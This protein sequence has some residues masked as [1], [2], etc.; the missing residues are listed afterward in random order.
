MEEELAADDRA[1]TSRAEFFTALN[2]DVKIIRKILCVIRYHLFLNL[3]ATQFVTALQKS[4]PEIIALR[5][6]F[7]E[8]LLSRDIPFQQNVDECPPNMFLGPVPGRNC[9]LASSGVFYDTKF[10]FQTRDIPLNTVRSFT[11]V[12]SSC[13]FIEHLHEALS[14]N[15]ELRLQQLDYLKKQQPD[16][17]I[18]VDPVTD[19]QHETTFAD[20]QLS[21]LK[22]LLWNTGKY[23]YDAAQLYEDLIGHSS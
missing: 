11:S 16:I 2:V 13:F 19:E 22:T 20:P 15:C 12:R 8:N 3:P 23:A 5:N 21:G 10:G 6:N 17:I 9:L 14:I 1:T 4:E 7:I 18:E